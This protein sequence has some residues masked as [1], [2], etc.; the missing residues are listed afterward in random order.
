VFCFEAKNS[1][2]NE[3]LG[4]TAVEG[5]FLPSGML[6]KH[7]LFEDGNVQVVEIHCN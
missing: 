3:S 4:T 1:T 6:M 5:I 7:I 2:I